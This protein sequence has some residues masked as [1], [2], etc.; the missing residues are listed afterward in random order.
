VR[1]ERRVVVE[2]EVLLVLVLVLPL[3]MERVLVPV[4][5]LAPY[6]E[7]AQ[8]LELRMLPLRVGSIHLGL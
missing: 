8:V 4:L 2:V 3:P 6:M 7:L 1:L 5:V